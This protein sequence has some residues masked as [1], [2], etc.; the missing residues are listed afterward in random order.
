MTTMRKKE[1]TTGQGLKVREQMSEKVNEQT[2]GFA[3]F[4]RSLVHPFAYINGTTDSS[5]IPREPFTRK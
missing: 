3:L 1:R 5:P 2:S 4:T